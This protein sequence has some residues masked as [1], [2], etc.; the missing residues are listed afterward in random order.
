MV[1]IFLSLVLTLRFPGEVDPGNPEFFRA[2]SK[3]QPW[4]V[5]IFLWLVVFHARKAN[6][7]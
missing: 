1:E 4:M 5:E 3:A 2:V 7:C 6:V